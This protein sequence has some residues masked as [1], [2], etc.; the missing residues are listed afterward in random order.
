MKKPTEITDQKK[1]KKK[2]NKNKSKNSRGVK[3]EPV[4]NGQT[5]YI[6]VN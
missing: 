6:R 5:N 2:K 4:C 1:K 3:Y